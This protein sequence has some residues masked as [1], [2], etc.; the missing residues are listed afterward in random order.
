MKILSEKSKRYAE[1]PVTYYI[2]QKGTKVSDMPPLVS[3]KRICTHTF[4]KH[5]SLGSTWEASCGRQG[6]KSCFQLQSLCTILYI[7]AYITYPKI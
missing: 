3:D 6:R 2:K 5:V 1:M 4:E 7:C